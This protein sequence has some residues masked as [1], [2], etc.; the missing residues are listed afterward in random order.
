MGRHTQK[1][2]P[3]QGQCQPTKNNKT[4]KK[5]LQ[6]YTATNCTIHNIKLNTTTRYKNING[7]INGETGN[8]GKILGLDH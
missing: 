4:N 2:K 8:G 6:N 1:A 5:K 3:V 7:H